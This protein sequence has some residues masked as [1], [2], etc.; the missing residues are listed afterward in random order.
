MKKNSRIIKE[1]EIRPKKIFDT[2]L[3][4]AKKDAYFFFQKVKK[5]NQNCPVCNKKTKHY[6]SKFNFK[7]SKC[8]YCETIYN[9]PRAE[10]KIFDDFYKYSKSVKFWSTDFYSKTSNARKKK[11]WIPKIS[12]IK[13]FIKN[14]KI[15]NVI[16]IG[17]GYG[18][19]LDVI[20]KKRICE[21]T[22]AVEPSSALSDICKKKKHKVVNKFLEELS[23]FDIPQKKNNLFTC[24]ELFEHV[25]DINLFVNKIY[26]V[27]KKKN[28]LILTTLSGTGV[29]IVNLKDKSKSIFPPHHVNFLNPYSM[30]ILFKKHKFKV[31]KIF[32]P[33]KLD[34]NIMQNNI[35]YIKNNFWRIF[36]SKAL[37]KEKDIMQNII[38]EMN[39][40][41]HM[42]VICQK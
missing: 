39:M 14:K 36:L 18:D 15:D 33:G 23:H 4:L 6:I 17:A 11:L 19:F 38:S 8:N 42:W 2:Y 25:H 7:Y 13:N 24:F 30:N 31:I 20:K 34:L 3:A 22:I 9:N 21:N 29:D 10:K 12:I 40:S 27:M 37:S 35:R 28:I 41:S 32:T 1:Y 26:K 5:K 16:D